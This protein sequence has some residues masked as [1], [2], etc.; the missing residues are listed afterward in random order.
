MAALR[1]YVQGS[2]SKAMISAMIWLWIASGLLML[3]A[4][5]IGHID[6]ALGLGQT[7]KSTIGWV[8]GWAL[9]PLFLVIG[10]VI[11]IKPEML[12]RAICILAFHSF[13]LLVLPYS[14]AL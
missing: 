10:S 5:I 7:I 14:S 9:I 1:W 6:W 12:I 3:I 11:N 13:I 4:L 8:K 2:E